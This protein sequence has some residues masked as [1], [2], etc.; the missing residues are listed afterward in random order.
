MAALAQHELCGLWH[1]K[2]VRT[3]AGVNCGTAGT[4]RLWGIHLRIQRVLPAG[5]ITILANFQL[6]LVTSVSG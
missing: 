6:A 3:P 5:A 4:A 2:A 1:D